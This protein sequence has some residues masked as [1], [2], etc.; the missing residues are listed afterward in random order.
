MLRAACAELA[1]RGELPLF[2]D[3]PR[4]PPDA[5]RLHRRMGVE[6]CRAVS[7]AVVRPTAG[8]RSFTQDA[9]SRPEPAHQVPV[10]AALVLRTLHRAVTSASPD[11]RTIA[12]HVDRV[13]GLVEGDAPWA[14]P[15]GVLLA[16]LCLVAAHAAPLLATDG[17]DALPAAVLRAATLV[18]GVPASGTQLRTVLGEAATEQEV[19]QLCSSEFGAESFGNAAHAAVMALLM[20]REMREDARC[21]V[22]ADLLGSGLLPVVDGNERTAEFVAGLGDRLGP[23]WRWPQSVS[24]DVA[25]G[26]AAAAAAGQRALGD[27]VRRH[28]AVADL[29]AG[30]L[31][32]PSLRRAALE[33]LALHFLS[34][35]VVRGEG[36]ERGPALSWS[37]R[38]ELAAIME[39]P[40]GRA[41]AQLMSK[42]AEIVIGVPDEVAVLLGR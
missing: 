2:A 41:N 31:T 36:A 40:K 18:A 13:A 21:V 29:D 26:S 11:A 1:A 24:L 15:P 25:I 19:V 33:L 42:V 8:I 5:P 20:C 14:L 7:G 37:A 9:E 27:V 16:A 4:A 30:D 23:G 35:L 38:T 3:L 17:D 39:S 6:T 12:A 34:R 10:S 28:A 22:W 32:R